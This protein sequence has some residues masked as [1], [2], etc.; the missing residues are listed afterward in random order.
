MAQVHQSTGVNEA[1][2]NLTVV[3]SLPYPAASQARATAVATVVVAARS[4]PGA[5]NV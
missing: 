3:A 2:R 5:P 4:S 1:A